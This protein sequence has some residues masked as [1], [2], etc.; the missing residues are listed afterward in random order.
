MATLRLPRLKISHMKVRPFVPGLI[1]AIVSP[2]IGSP[3]GASTLTTF[4]PRSARTAPADGTNA[5]IDTST[6][7]IPSSGC[8]GSDSAISGA[9]L[10]E[11]LCITQF[12]WRQAYAIVWAA[13]WNSQR[14]AACNRSPVP[15]TLAQPWPDRPAFQDGAELVAGQGEE[16]REGVDGPV[17]EL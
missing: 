12:H 16:P 1:P 2:R 10:V 15:P 17:A 5:H 3:C 13:L 4:A 9:H 8:V 14:A 6:T 11:S 7:R